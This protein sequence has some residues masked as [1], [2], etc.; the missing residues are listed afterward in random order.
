[1][2]SRSGARRA[3]D[4]PGSRDRAWSG[5]RAAGE[6]QAVAHLGT[7]YL[8]VAAVGPAGAR[9]ALAAADGAALA[10]ALAV[11]LEVDAQG[12]ATVGSGC[13]T[14]RSATAGAVPTE[15]AELSLHQLAVAVVLLS[16]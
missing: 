9:N 11:R 3:S 8:A 1:M 7:L 15:L 16:L 14:D 10:A 4:E 2:G 13:G 12:A 6:R 5:R